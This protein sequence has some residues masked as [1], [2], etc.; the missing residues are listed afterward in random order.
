MSEF[1]FNTIFEPMNSEQFAEERK[2]AALRTP[3]SLKVLEPGAPIKP[4]IDLSSLA[5]SDPI[6][7]SPKKLT[8]YDTHPYVDM[9]QRIKKNEEH[10]QLLL[11]RIQRLEGYCG[12]LESE[13]KK[14]KEVDNLH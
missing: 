5:I 2:K 13:R 9:N 1:S 7:I 4:P 14:L 6:H 12:M 3:K 10:T 8:Y 11:G